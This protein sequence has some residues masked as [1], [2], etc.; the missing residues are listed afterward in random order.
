M[1][2]T[3]A[4][5]INEEPTEPQL[6]GEDAFE[7]DDNI[8]AFDVH[9]RKGEL[10]GWMYLKAFSE[11]SL[12]KYRE[13]RNGDGFRKKGNAA[14]AL[15]FWI[16][17]CYPMEAPKPEMVNIGFEFAGKLKGAAL[18]L[19]KYQVGDQRAR[20]IAF[21]RACGTL[22]DTIHTAWFRH[23]LPDVDLHKSGPGSEDDSEG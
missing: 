10:I 4:G 5:K 15:R 1:E 6:V 13:I 11:P 22:L 18:D 2:G 7:V 8:A 20:E 21:F 12:Y 3:E 19:R 14:A 17:K 23:F 9:N 16:D